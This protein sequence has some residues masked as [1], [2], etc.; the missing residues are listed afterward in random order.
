MGPG[1]Q[2]AR[3]FLRD[4]V[5]FDETGEQ[6]LPEQLHHGIGVP[7]LQAVKGAVFAEASIRRQQVSVRVPLDQVPGG[8]DGDDDTRTNLRIELSAHVLDEAAAHERPQHPLDHRPQG[9]V[10]SRET[11]GPRVQQLL[12]VLFKQTVQRGLARPPRLVDSAADLHAQPEAGGRV[13][14][15]KGGDTPRSDLPTTRQV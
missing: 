7:A 11:L 13:A 10:A 9:P 4:R 5:P 2:L 15:G 1:D 12:E 8:G 3:E 6:A 14:G